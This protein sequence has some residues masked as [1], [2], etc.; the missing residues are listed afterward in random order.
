M[1]R[2]VAWGFTLDFGASLLLLESIEVLGPHGEPLRHVVAGLL[3][4]APVVLAN[5]F[6]F[7]PMLTGLGRWPRGRR[8]AVRWVAV[9][10]AGMAVAVP[11]GFVAGFL[12]SLLTIALA[13]LARDG[14]PTA[15][16]LPLAAGA[17]IGVT[18]GGMVVGWAG[19]FLRAEPDRRRL[20][21][22]GGGAMAALIAVL[23]SVLL[24]ARSGDTTGWDWRWTV[25]LA[26]ID[27]SALLP[28][29]VLTRRGPSQGGQSE[30]GPRL[31]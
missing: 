11:A 1:A 8:A 13:A 16:P 3:V 19:S 21:D 27:A 9:A 17:L 18:A 31:S 6:L 20:R 15:S 23:G 22:L 28:H 12:A 4:A 26:A 24:L 5:H 2:W 30:P 10:V 7:V 14:S 25:G 29:L